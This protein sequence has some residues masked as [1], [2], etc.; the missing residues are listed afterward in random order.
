MEA[1][2]KTLDILRHGYTLLKQ[3]DELTVYQ[4]IYGEDYKVE[5]WAFGN[6]FSIDYVSPTNSRNTIADRYVVETQEQLDFLLTRS[7]R[8][9][10]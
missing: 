1:Q 10:F 2:G 3:E 7:S 8:L 5:V 6:C 4:K 9:K